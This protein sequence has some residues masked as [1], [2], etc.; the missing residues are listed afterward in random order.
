MHLT[1]PCPEA[2][3]HNFGRA[4]A[5]PMD[6]LANSSTGKQL[7]ALASISRANLCVARYIVRVKERIMLNAMSQ[8]ATRPVIGHSALAHPC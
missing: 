6:N 2:G 7:N 3:W 5:S 8:T 1:I 4:G